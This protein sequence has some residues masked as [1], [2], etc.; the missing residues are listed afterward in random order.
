MMELFAQT[1]TTQGEN[2]TN[3]HFWDREKLKRK[4]RWFLRERLSKQ[5]QHASYRDKVFPERGKR[6]LGAPRR[7]H[8]SLWKSGILDGCLIFCRRAS[9]FRPGLAEMGSCENRLEKTTKENPSSPTLAVFSTKARRHAKKLQRKS[10]P[11]SKKNPRGK[12][13]HFRPAS[14]AIPDQKKSPVRV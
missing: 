12:S 9:F 4:K 2:T 6:I 14:T 8:R 11:P 13:A 7:S 5:I 1:S 10:G 3:L